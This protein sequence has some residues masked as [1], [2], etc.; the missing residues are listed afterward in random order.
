MMRW[1]LVPLACCCLA[2]LLPG[3]TAAGRGAQV[4]HEDSAET[5]GVGPAELTMAMF[6]HSMTAAEAPYTLCEF[7][8]SWCPACMN[9]KP[10]YAR[11]A[12]LFNA[13]PPGEGFVYVAAVDCATETALCQH[14]G[15]DRY[16]TLLWGDP[17]QFATNLRPG[18]DARAGLAVAETA[19]T[20]EAVLNWINEK[21]HQSFS[22]TA[23]AEAH[24]EAAGQARA[25]T[26][27]ERAD[28]QEAL[29]PTQLW[30]VEEA[31]ALAFRYMLAAVTFTTVAA[32]R[33]SVARFAHLVAE[34]HP[35]GR[36]RAGA[37]SLVAQLDTVWPTAPLP[38]EADPADAADVQLAVL[39]QVAV[40]GAGVPHSQKGTWRSCQG[41]TAD[42][43][44]YSCGL[45]Q[46]FHSLAARLDAG[47]GGAAL[48]ALRGFVDVGFQCD[49]CRRHFLEASAA[50][51]AAAVTTRREAALWLWGMHNRVNVR[52]AKAEDESGWGDPAFPKRLWPPRHACPDCR[53]SPESADA[54]SEGAVEWDEDAVYRFLLRHYRQPGGDNPEVADILGGDLQRREA[55]LVLA[56]GLPGVAAPQG[57]AVRGVVGGVVL[58]GGVGAVGWWWQGRRRRRKSP[59]FVYPRVSKE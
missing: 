54:G 35:S 4:G 14:F 21:T 15:V 19:R 33:P 3:C 47:E 11:V 40:C 53:K 30:D 46:L 58:L 59:L 17:R 24:R 16:P 8:A 31:T 26:Q 41:S 50:P 9:F 39:Q 51:D 25:V 38:G 6:N 27:Q 28:R 32:A 1:L 5:A 44:G 42:T 55:G 45:W 7:F 49:E 10:Q 23:S 36:C 29:A 34:H 12:A 43:R 52:L 37:A 56:E 22:L 57:Q 2:A 13:A 18:S 48:A 20:A